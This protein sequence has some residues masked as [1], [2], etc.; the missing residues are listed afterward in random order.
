MIQPLINV[1]RL[2]SMSLLPLVF[3]LI[4]AGSLSAQEIFFSNRVG[5]ELDSSE[6][7][8]FN[9]FPDIQNFVSA[10][11]SRGGDTVVNFI[12]DRDGGLGETTVST[13]MRIV[14]ELRRYIDHYEKL[15]TGDTLQLDWTGV[16]MIVHPSMPFR[17]DA[18]VLNVLT[19]SGEHIRGPVLHANDN[20]LVI[21]TSKSTQPA[22]VI[23]GSFRIINV[24][25]IERVQDGRS[26]AGRLLYTF[27]IPVGGNQTAF[28]ERVLPRVQSDLFYVNGIPPE[29]IAMLARYQVEPETIRL[30][31]A[32]DMIDKERGGDLFAI[33]NGTDSGIRGRRSGTLWNAIHLHVAKG[34]VLYRHETLLGSYQGWTPGPEF[35]SFGIDLSV[36]QWLRFGISYSMWQKPGNNS[37]P[38]Q[39]FY[40]VFGDELQVKL[41]MLPFRPGMSNLPLLNRLEMAVESGIAMRYVTERYFDQSSS[42]TISGYMAAIATAYYPVDQISIGPVVRAMFYPE[43]D[44]G[45]SAKVPLDSYDLQFRISIH[46]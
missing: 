29:L 12:I 4:S 22:E 37:E 45:N 24:L 46:L 28:Q 43:A 18:A 10:R 32:M 21:A 41:A 8:Y 33:I 42:E 14:G 20:S 19:R 30:P 31:V 39:Y 34:E 17:D 15:Y 2:M 38:I 26:I 27:D 25:E 1:R 11:A 44:R 23:A 3:I 9:F 35:I 16:G 40:T 36:V 5:I 7:R 6:R 13:S